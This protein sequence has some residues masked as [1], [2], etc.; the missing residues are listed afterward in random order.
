MNL[1]FD[2]IGDLFNQTTAAKPQTTT[3]V[4][5][6]SQSEA[7]ESTA[8]KAVI[9]Q[10]NTSLQAAQEK[11]VNIKAE[12]NQLFIERE[13]L[14]NIM[15]LAVSTGTN[16][17]MLGKP[18][19]GKTNITEELCNRIE[20]AQYFSWMLNKTSDPSEILGSFSVKEME[21][22]KFMRV[23][24]G[25]LPEA[26][27]SFMD[28]VYK[29]NAPTLN[30]L[31]TI[32]NEHVFYNDGRKIPVPLISMFGASNEPPEDESLLALHDRFIFRINVEY[33]KSASNK[34]RMFDNYVRNRAAG[35][36]QK[37]TTISLDEVKML[38]DA[39]RNVKVTKTIMN[40]FLGVIKEL[41]NH[42][43]TVS[44]RR[45]NEC[46][47]VMQG[48]AVLRG[49]NSVAL[50][51]F[52]SLT[53]VLW[54][55]EEDLPIIE[56]IINKAANPYDDR[57]AKIKADFEEIRNSIESQPEGS[58]ERVQAQ[59]HAKGNIGKVTTKLNKLINEASKGGRDI[60][61]FAN[62]RQDMTE[63]TEQ[64]LQNALGTAIKI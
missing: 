9:N 62:L 59:M 1:N 27:I 5:I 41:E 18:G 21:N 31:L 36:N 20:N 60:T 48:A 28:E 13:E 22:D 29:S 23:T 10:N 57:F 32:M 16:L 8:P 54:E 46:F 44:D 45:Q 38:Q 50:D 51:D 40:A 33:I 58:K 63:Y 25:K 2:D 55:N 52:R 34:I 53:Y 30:A 49:G 26:H 39:G 42:N 56:S 7:T 6:N 4:Q 14:I 15:L 17:L 35:S 12:L 43:I 37:K 61:E 3:T 47:K 24:K 64:V 19:T 11:I